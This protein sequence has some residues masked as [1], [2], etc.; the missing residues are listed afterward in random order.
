MPELL[1]RSTQ[2]IIV[3]M[4]PWVDILMAEPIETYGATLTQRIIAR[5]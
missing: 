5:G 1:P 4:I 2:G 3:R